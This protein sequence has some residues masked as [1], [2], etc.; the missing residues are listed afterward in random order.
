M[1]KRR[2]TVRMVV[3]V[4]VPHWMTAAQAR[5]EVR[6][7]VGSD[8]SGYLSHGPDYEEVSVRCKGV[9]PAPKEA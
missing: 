1:A 5:R 3:E 7:S 6:Y 9:R 4:T 2:K 8:N